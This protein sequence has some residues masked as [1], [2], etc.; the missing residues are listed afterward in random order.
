MEFF[1]SGLYLTQLLPAWFLKLQSGHDEPLWS[2]MNVPG[3][4]QP[5]QLALDL[6]ASKRQSLDGDMWRHLRDGALANRSTVKASGLQPE[7][8]GTPYSPWPPNEQ[9]VKRGFNPTDKSRS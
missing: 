5:H 8:P 2:G 6:W 1:V 9:P 4:A 7:E 3:Y